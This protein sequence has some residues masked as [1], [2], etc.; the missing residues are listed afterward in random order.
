MLVRIHI[1][2]KRVEKIL[3]ALQVAWTRWWTWEQKWYCPDV[4]H[5][6]HHRREYTEEDPDLQNDDD[7][8]EE[9]GDD[10]SMDILRYMS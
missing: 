5:N 4:P 9:E 3:E 1:I 10:E 7:E 8:E 6:I 2:Q